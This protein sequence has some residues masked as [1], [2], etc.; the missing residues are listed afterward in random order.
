MSRVARCVRRTCP[1]CV[2][3][4]LAVGGNHVRIWQQQGTGAWF[5]AASEEMNVRK[6]HMIVPDGYNLGRDKVV[7]Q[8]QQRKNGVT[9]VECVCC[10][11]RSADPGAARSSSRSTR[12]ASS[13]SAA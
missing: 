12:R 13:T 7:A 8:S 5:L 10:T 6:H 1:L 11:A 3:L 2:G 4:R 9:W